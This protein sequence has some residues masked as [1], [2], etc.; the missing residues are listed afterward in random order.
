MD[1]QIAKLHR[2]IYIWEKY[3]NWNECF[4]KKKRNC[5]KIFLEKNTDFIIFFMFVSLEDTS[6]KEDDNDIATSNSAPI[7]PSVIDA[8]IS[9]RK[10]KVTL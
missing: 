1:K 10:S 2:A 3:R 6:Y 5:D 9:E 4:Y 7:E 8:N